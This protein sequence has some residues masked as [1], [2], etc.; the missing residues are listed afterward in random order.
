MFPLLLTIKLLNSMK[1]D[2][3][4]L[5]HFKVLF[6]YWIYYVILSQVENS[7][8]IRLLDAS[9]ATA[10]AILFFTIKVWLFYGKGCLILSYYYLSNAS[11]KLI[12]NHSQLANIDIIE[13]KFI[14][15]LMNLTLLN[16][17]IISRVLMLVGSV[18]GTNN[19]ISCIFESI[20]QFVIELSTTS[21][22]SPVFLTTG[23]NHFCIIDNQV[24]YKHYKLTNQFLNIF[25][26]SQ[27]QVQSSSINMKK[28]RLQSS[29]PEPQ[30]QH[31]G[32]R[33]GSNAS[34]RHLA[35]EMS[36][37]TSLSPTTS[38]R[39]AGQRVPLQRESRS[40][41]EELTR[42]EKPERVVSDPVNNILTKKARSRSSS[43]ASQLNL[44]PSAIPLE[45]FIDKETYVDPPYPL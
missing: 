3:R 14:D 20:N 28:L 30:L 12:G 26:L 8:F 33:R 36:P 18:F 1:N 13:Y 32:L 37:N 29:T 24:V 42:I 44:P 6:N 39:L 11:S 9:L 23:L 7:L 40:L 34:S 17:P 2:L 38:P 4:Q 21:K 31:H 15:P 27:P 35:S 5:Q 45:N 25:R 16:S 10:V 41:F 22:K 43:M 19:I